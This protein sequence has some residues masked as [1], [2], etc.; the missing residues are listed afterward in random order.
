MQ[1][2]ALMLTRKKLV[3]CTMFVI[4]LFSRFYNLNQQPV[5]EDN[6]SWLYRLNYYP[7]IL[8]TNFKGHPENG[9]NL[10]YAGTLSYHPGVTVMTLSGLTTRIGKK[11]LAKTDPAYT[12]CTYNDANCKYLSAELF[13]AKLPLIILGAMLVLMCALLIEK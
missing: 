7:W 8:E 5:W 10:K 2:P 4:Y 6:F 3:F 12:P 11:I 1:I 13:M 9:K